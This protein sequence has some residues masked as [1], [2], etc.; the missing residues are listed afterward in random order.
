[1]NKKELHKLITESIQEVISEGYAAKHYEQQI[2]KCIPLVMNWKHQC[3]NGEIRKVNDR[4]YKVSGN[5]KINL[6]PYNKNNEYMQQKFT[7]NSTI[8]IHFHYYPETKIANSIMADTKYI[9]QSP[10]SKIVVD[11]F[12]N[13]YINERKLKITMLHE[14]THVLDFRLGEWK[15]SWI[16]GSGIKTYNH[17]SDSINTLPKYIKMPMY[18][19]WSTSEFN[20]WQASYDWSDEKGNMTNMI[21][22]IMNYLEQASNDNNPETWEKLKNYLVQSSKTRVIGR[23]FNQNNKRDFS[24][25]PIESVKHYFLKTS[26]NKLKKFIQKIK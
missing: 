1:M 23:T 20:A 26:F 14:M 10:L 21:E 19:L 8:P 17:Q 24:N 5:I 13:K 18:Y 25:T 22:E 6:K 12:F 9:A 11:V 3:D 4:G 2:D 7:K 16:V 15:D